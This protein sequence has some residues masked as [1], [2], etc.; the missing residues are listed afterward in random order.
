M[1]ILMRIFHW[2]FFLVLALTCATLALVFQLPPIPQDPA[3]HAFADRR[4]LAGIPNFLNVASSVAFLLV[5]ATGVLHCL[6]R[7]RTDS[8]TAWLV[9]FSAVALVGIGSAYYHWSPSSATLVWDR[10]PMTVGFMALCIAV[11]GETSESPLVYRLLW[12]AIALGVYSIVEWYR[13]DDLRLY[14]WIQFFPLLLVPVALLI[15]PVRWTQRWL[16]G[17]A[18]GCYVLAKF[19][20]LTDSRLFELTGAVISGHTLK[21]LL[22]AAACYCILR[23]LQRRRLA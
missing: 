18:L 9:F 19:A 3:Y 20:E 17:A 6:V 23:M 14:A 13:A 5:G 22:A 2:P 8:R 1:Q 4:A 7:E 15:T 21:H 12:P 11:L 10:L 16:L